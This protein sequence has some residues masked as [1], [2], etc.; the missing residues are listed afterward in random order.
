MSSRAAWKDQWAQLGRSAH[1][2]ADY[3]EKAVYDGHPHPGRD[4]AEHPEWSSTKYVDE[5]WDGQSL[6]VLADLNAIMCL[7]SAADHL[8]LL[9]TGLR[10]CT[11]SLATAARGALEAASYAAFLAGPGISPAERARRSL[12][13][14]LHSTHENVL[15]YRMVAPEQVAEEENYRDGLIEA[16]KKRSEFGP[17]HKGDDIRTPRFGEKPKITDMVEPLRKTQRGDNL[18]LLSYKGLSSSVHARW[19]GWVVAGIATVLPDGEMV[20]PADRRSPRDV[21]SVHYAALIA[22][23]NASLRVS[24]RLG[25]DATSFRVD[26]LGDLQVWDRI[27][28][29]DSYDSRP[30]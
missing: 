9:G 13:E 16:G 10:A 27:G 20:W 19:N 30:P 15:T 7:M 4:N 1:H 25:W 23:Y 2:L 3:V 28:K 21:A 12:N 5:A 8:N 11:S 6:I 24:E 18:G 26:G 17:F 14:V 22:A 29:P